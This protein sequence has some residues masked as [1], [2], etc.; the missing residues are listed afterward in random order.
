MSKRYEYSRLKWKQKAPIDAVFCKLLL[1]IVSW[2]KSCE[3]F[4]RCIGSFT[5][6]LR[7]Y[8]SMYL[9]IIYGKSPLCSVCNAAMFSTLL[10]VLSGSSSL[11][12]LYA[13][14]NTFVS[15]REYL[16][17][18]LSVFWNIFSCLGSKFRLIYNNY[19][20]LVSNISIPSIS[21]IL[22]KKWSIAIAYMIWF[23]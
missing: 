19:A 2:T 18:Y 17:F 3:S 9:Y 7:L 13:W 4:F 5:P 23:N 21:L 22:I 8:L 14:F 6:F 15:L 20:K 12:G 11:M 1:S 10:L 16:I